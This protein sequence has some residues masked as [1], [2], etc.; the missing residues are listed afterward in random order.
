MEEGIAASGTQR[1]TILW[2]YEK[3]GTSSAE[4]R[5]ERSVLSESTHSLLLLA[6]CFSLAPSAYMP[7]LSL[8]P[9]I[10]H[11]SNMAYELVRST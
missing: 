6:S 5:L 1:E 10:L 7:S 2:C 8:Y 3:A 4:R 11:D 9:Q